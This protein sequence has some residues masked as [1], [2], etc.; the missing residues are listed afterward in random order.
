[1]DEMTKNELGSFEAFVLL[2]WFLTGEEI[3]S[4]ST[5]PLTNELY[6]WWLA[7]EDRKIIHESA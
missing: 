5:H 4:I 1:V 2:H 7:I 6:Y 3:V